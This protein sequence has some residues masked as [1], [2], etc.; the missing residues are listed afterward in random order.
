MNSLEIIKILN[1]MVKNTKYVETTIN[2][3]MIRK[4]LVI[5]KNPKK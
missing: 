3:D 1:K 5:D 4:G 2:V